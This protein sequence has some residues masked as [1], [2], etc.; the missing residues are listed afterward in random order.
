MTIAYIA[1]PISGD[2]EANLADICRIV[3][4]INLE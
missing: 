3:R 2:V 1:H 4:K